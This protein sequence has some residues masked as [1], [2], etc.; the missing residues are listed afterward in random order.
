MNATVKQP[1]PASGAEL[2]IE[3]DPRRLP[4]PGS[5]RSTAT[6]SPTST[7]PRRHSGPRAVI[8]AIS[9]YYEHDHANVHRGVHTLSH[10]ATDAYEGAREKVRAIHQCGFDARNRVH[11]R[12]D[13]S[14]QPG[15]LVARGIDTGTAGDEIVISHLEHHSNIVPWQMLC[16]RSGTELR[17]VPINERGELR[18]DEFHGHAG[19]AYPPRVGRARVECAR[20]RISPVADIVAAAKERDIPVLL[21]GAQAIPHQPV[22]VTALGCDF[23][24]FSGHKMFGA[25]RHRRAVRA[26]GN[27][28]SGCRPTR[29][30]AT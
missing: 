11:A 13:R 12:H 26:R 10:R 9:R 25:D 1:R 14:H 18:M 30:A 7:A 29:G 19:S 4:D 27:G 17:V 21:D 2:D 5:N 8:D 3:P 24:A 22:D 20:H 6:G 15:R 16:E 28:S 23:Y